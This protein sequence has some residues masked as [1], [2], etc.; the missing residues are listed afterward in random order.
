LAGAADVVITTPATVEDLDDTVRPDLARPTAGGLW[1]NILDPRPIASA[2]AG[3][4]RGPST[5]TIGLVQ[6]SE[7]IEIHDGVRHAFEV[8]T[9]DL[10]RLHVGLETAGAAFGARSRAG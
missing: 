10:D 6:R 4:P 2:V 8:D 1:R 3:S 7:R 9:R 5:L